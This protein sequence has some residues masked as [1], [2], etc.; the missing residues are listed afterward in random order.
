M[1]SQTTVENGFLR[2]LSA[3]EGEVSGLNQL[4][5][6]VAIEFDPLFTDIFK[7]V[8]AL[9]KMIANILNGVDDQPDRGADTPLDALFDRTP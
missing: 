3:L 4:F 8:V 2:W 9:M 7:E 1:H 5:F 6:A